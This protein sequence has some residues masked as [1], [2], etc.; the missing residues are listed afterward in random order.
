MR[1]TVGVV[2]PG[3]RAVVRSSYVNIYALAAEEASKIKT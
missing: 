1:D 3:I 2:P